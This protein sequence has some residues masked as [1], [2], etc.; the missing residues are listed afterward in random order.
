MILSTNPLAHRTVLTV[1][2]AENPFQGVRRISARWLTGKFGS[3]PSASGHHRLDE[4]SVLTNQA[5]YLTSGAEHAIRLQ[6]REDKAEATWRT[7]ITAVAADDTS[8]LLSVSLEVFPNGSTPLPS[9][10]PRLVCDLVQEFK[11]VDGPAPLA[12]KAHDTGSEGVDALIDV[13]CDPARRMPVIVAAQP[14]RPNPLWSQRIGAVMRDCAGAASLY[15]LTDAE[16]VDAFRAAIGEHHRVAPGSVRTFLP[17]VDPAWPDDAP[18]HRFLTVARLGDPQDHAWRGLARTVQRLSTEA[19]LPDALRSLSFPDDDG[20]RRREERQAALAAARPTG[21]LAKMRTDVEELRA[22]LAQADEELKE[23]SRTAD[24]ST[25]TISSLEDQLHAA[26]ARA[27]EDMEEALRAL[28][29]VERARAE[30]NTLRRRLREAG[31]YEDAVLVEQPSGTPD[32]FEELWDRLDAFEG[33]LV[34]ADKGKALQLD[35]AERARVWTAKAWN[36]LR[37]LDSYADAAKEGFNGGFH[38]YCTAGRPGSV[39]WPLKQLATAESESTMNKWGTERLFTVPSEIDPSERK[40]MQAHLKLDSKGSASPR[41]YFLDDTK[42]P[43]GRV[44][45]GYIGT[46]LTNTKTN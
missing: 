29:D 41:V 23:A 7:T 1:P 38:Q 12:L 15:L 10:R 31:R 25:R 14:L 34:T 40:E 22:L 26:A 44:I 24:L 30:A 35:E 42:G 33:I 18:R 46:H 45:V 28:D 6:L 21:E 19:P 3:A 11:P 37:A 17:E 39:T 13:L 9:A 36:A 2:H 16:T 8:A 5:S 43:T 32:S 20:H 4:V 27:D